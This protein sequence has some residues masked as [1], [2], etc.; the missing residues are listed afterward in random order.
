MS[1]NAARLDAIHNPVPDQRLTPS[2]ALN[3]AEL[4]GALS[5]ALDLTEGQP[6]GH[7]KRACWIGT[8][9]AAE[10]GVS[11]EELSD[12]YFT[13]LLKDLGCSSNA[14]RICELYLADDLSFKRDYKTVD[15]SLS[16][17]L[18]FVFQKTGL[19]SGFAE[20][21]RA[22]LN[23]LRN[24]GDISRELIETRCHRGAD[25]AGKMRFS[26]VVQDGI[27]WLDEHWDGSGKPERRTGEAIPLASRIALAAQ[28]TD[29]F[30]TEGGRMAARAELVA[31]SGGWFDPAVVEAFLR[32]ET[33]PGFWEAIEGVDLDERLFALPPALGTAALTEDY[34]DD[35]AAAFAD[36]IDAKSPFT[37]GHSRRVT[38]FTDMIAEEMGM[39]GDRRRWLRRAALLHDIGKLAVSNQILDK[40]GKPTDDEWQSIRNHPAHSANILSK[41]SVFREL[42]EVAGAHHE[43][44]DG[45][46]Y[47]QG[48]SSDELPPEVRMLTVADVFDALTADR[49][50]RGAMKVREAL[51]ILERDIGTAFDGDCVGALKRALVRLAPSDE[52]D[53]PQLV[54][55]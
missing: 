11:A 40:P 33:K 30:H 6:V 31:R 50:Y 25:I 41:I 12:I 53:A 1:T 23:I 21:V 7:S 48:L 3:L 47:P 26:P 45:K 36:V 9:I 29:V 17:A 32:A 43:R 20:R 38:L 27:R 8:H 2:G 10:M 5:H 14:A 34:I 44:I 19:E 54:W 13:V 4:L 49:P 55:N 37:A 42:A 51:A 15:G 22:I 35:I 39:P 18:R 28:I 16:A 46:G 52:P 24:G